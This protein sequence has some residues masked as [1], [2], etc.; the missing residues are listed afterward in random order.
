MTAQQ[1]LPDMLAFTHAA[2]ID[3]AAGR[4]MPDMT[5]IVTAGRI[6]AVGKSSTLRVPKGAQIVDASGKFLI[7]GL[8][9]M[10]VHIADEQELPLYVANG[11]TG[12][13]VMWGLPVHHEW[14]MAIESGSLTGPRMFIGSRIVDGPLPVWSESIS[15]RNEQEAREAVRQAR[16]E[17]A[18]FIKVYEVLPRE[19]FFALVDESKKQGLSF[20]G[21]VPQWFRLAKR[22]MQG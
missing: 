12:V 17:G 15:V 1:P 18:E 22:P 6:S 14:R 7:P 3:V 19:A 5:V 13:R 11:V 9:D 10:H 20:A 2:A 16:A 4:V 21:H 8:W